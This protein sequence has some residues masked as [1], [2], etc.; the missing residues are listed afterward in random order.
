MSYTIC[1]RNRP[2]PSN[3]ST[4]NLQCS[5]SVSLLASGGWPVYLQAERI[6]GKTLISQ[7]WTNR[8]YPS[9]STSLGFLRPFRC[10]R[11]LR[12]DLWSAW[13][14]CLAIKISTYQRAMCESSNTFS[15]LSVVSL[16]SSSDL[17]A[18][19]LG[20]SSLVSSLVSS[21]GSSSLVSS[22]VSS[23]GSSLV[24]SFAS[25]LV[26]SLGSSLGSSSASASG[27]ACASTLWGTWRW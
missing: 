10:Y 6:H 15:E 13:R 17:E 24:S 12:Q 7:A 3:D 25:S 19:A 14:P 26:S 4:T 5:Q 22:L 11:T 27:S 8:Q 2:T 16:A 1:T 9:T 18:S 20:F 21:L 23:L